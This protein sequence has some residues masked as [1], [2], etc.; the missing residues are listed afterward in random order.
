MK[1]KPAY[2]DGCLISFASKTSSSK[3]VIC[4]YTCVRVCHDSMK[5]DY[6]FLNLFGFLLGIPASC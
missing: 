3:A 4:N 1:L 6:L 2:L 5:P